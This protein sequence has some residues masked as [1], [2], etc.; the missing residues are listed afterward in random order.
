M[1]TDSAYRGTC[2]LV[3][4]SAN[5]QYVDT[6]ADRKTALDAENLIRERVFGQ[7]LEAHDIVIPVDHVVRVVYAHRNSDRRGEPQYRSFAAMSRA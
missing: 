7:C 4:Q 1:K 2:Q 6:V 5:N 3:V